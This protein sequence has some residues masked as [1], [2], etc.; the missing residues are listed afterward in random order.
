MKKY[1]V[2]AVLPMLFHNVAY[3]VDRDDTIVTMQDG[4]LDSQLNRAIMVPLHNACKAMNKPIHN[5]FNYVLS[6]LL[7]YAGKSR[8][9]KIVAI[10]Q[11]QKIQDALLYYKSLQYPTKWS[12]WFGTNPEIVTEMIDPALDKIDD[13]LESLDAYKIDSR[14]A[15]LFTPVNTL[16]ATALVVY[17]IYAAVQVNRDIQ[18]SAPVSD[19]AASA[20]GN[21]QPEQTFSQPVRSGR[22]TKMRVGQEDEKFK[23]EQAGIINVAGRPFVFGVP[24]A[25]I[26]GMMLGENVPV[27]PN[28]QDQFLSRPVASQRPTLVG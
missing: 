20:S 14:Y 6:A 2:L 25:R 19:S 13:A 7:S 28:L 27:R 10:D 26:Y 22:S 15:A 16:I 5:D 12:E 24:A 9:N 8:N 23:N 17:S 21:A 4:Y 3:C 11:I 18:K 1:I